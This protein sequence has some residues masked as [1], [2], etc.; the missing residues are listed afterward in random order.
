MEP[1][2]KSVIKTSLKV[3]I[4]SRVKKPDTYY[5]NIELSKLYDKTAHHLISHRYSSFVSLH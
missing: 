4:Q 5:F 1:E 2:L 3:E